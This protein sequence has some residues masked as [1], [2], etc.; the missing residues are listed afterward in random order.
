M[1]GEN[2][3]V[4]T[5]GSTSFNFGV[6]PKTQIRKCV[7]VF[8]NT[9]KSPVVIN[10]TKTACNCT[11]IQYTASPVQPGKKGYVTVSYNGKGYHAGHFR[12]SVDVITNAENGLVRLFIEGE[13]K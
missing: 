9:G 1:A 13:T 12:K 7:F 10:A 6:F 8:K 4:V 5:F 11:S 3:G 2:K